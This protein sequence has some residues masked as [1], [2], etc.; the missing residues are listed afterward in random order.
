MSA[1]SKFSQRGGNVLGEF[2]R[3]FTLIDVQEF[4]KLVWDIAASCERFRAEK[5]VHP[6]FSNF[7]VTYFYSVLLNREDLLTTAEV[8]SLKG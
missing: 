5:I 7:V 2:V 3:K 4:W 1:G 8:D 6:D